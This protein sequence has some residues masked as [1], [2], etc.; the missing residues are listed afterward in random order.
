V[1]AGQRLLDDLGLDSL[2]YATVL[3]SCEQWLGIA[4][5][6]DGIDWRTVATVEELADFFLEQ[7]P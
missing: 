3:L 4:I 1:S 5:D 6:E 7:R 2:D